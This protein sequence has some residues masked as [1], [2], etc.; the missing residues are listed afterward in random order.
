M[1][2]QIRGG[3]ADRNQIHSINQAIQITDF[4]QRTRTAIS[5][6]INVLFYTVFPTS[7]LQKYKNEFWRLVLADIYAQ[8][9]DSAPGFVY[10]DAIML[11]T[12]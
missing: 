1:K 5:N 12:I 7:Y 8:P 11:D 4:D 3:F 9:I 6:E 2:V 10:N